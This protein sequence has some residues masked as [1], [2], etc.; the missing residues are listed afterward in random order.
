MRHKL[1]WVEL[2]DTGVPI[3]IF[4]NR[5]AAY[6][7]GKEWVAPTSRTDAVHIIRR[8]LWMRSKGDCELCGA[9]VTEQSGEMHERQHRGKGGEISMENSV[10]A[11]RACHRK[12]HADRAPRWSKKHPDQIRTERIPNYIQDGETICGHGHR[13]FDCTVCRKSS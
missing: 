11:C 6:A 5:K 4:K 1:V 10:F 3:R 2:S 13:P 12:A 9:P 7:F 8:Q